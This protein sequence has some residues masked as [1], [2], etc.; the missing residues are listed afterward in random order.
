MD[1]GY[2]HQGIC[3]LGHFHSGHILPDKCITMVNGVL[4]YIPSYIKKLNMS[5][6]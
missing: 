1:V 5:R 2:F 6:S 3:P 4:I